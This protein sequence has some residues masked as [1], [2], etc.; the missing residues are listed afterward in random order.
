MKDNVNHPSHYTAG[1]IECI[2]ALESLASGYANPIHAGLAWQVVKY[3]W[4]APL[5][6]D[7]IEDLQKAQWYL[8]RL[9]GKVSADA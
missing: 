4:R 9:I 7:Q 5:K 3:I 6:N 8:N 1:M 2:D